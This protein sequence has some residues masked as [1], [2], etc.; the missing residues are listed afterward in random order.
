MPDFDV[1]SDRL[2]AL[3][4]ESLKES[5]P[6]QSH[7]SYLFPCR[8]NNR[9]L[10]LEAE[11]RQKRQAI[12]DSIGVDSSPTPPVQ[13][14]RLSG[15]PTY[16][17]NG[18]DPSPT[19]PL[20]GE[21]LSDSPFPGREG[22]WGVRSADRQNF[23]PA[24]PTNLPH[25]Q[26][27][28]RNRWLELERELQARR[29]SNILPSGVQSSIPPPPSP[30]PTI[31][32]QVFDDNEPIHLQ[33]PSSSFPRADPPI[34]NNAPFP[35]E[36]ATVSDTREVAKSLDEGKSA[37]IPSVNFTTRHLADADQPSPDKQP[38]PVVP[39]TSKPSL[40]KSPTLEELATALLEIINQQNRPPVEVTTS[41][42][43]LSPPQPEINAN[44]GNTVSQQMGFNMPY[45]TEFDLG[46]MEL[47]QLFDTFDREIEQTE[48]AKVVDLEQ[49]FEE[50]DRA[51]DA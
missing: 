50:F 45:A 22:G 51:L 35:Q 11:L 21:G 38:P 41:S 27:R 14:E 25:Y 12:R 34:G 18:F 28:G 42:T 30:K 6:S 10:A 39:D 24:P 40:P 7:S 33:Y 36:V 5:C 32:R 19:P 47:E 16:P 9:L 31:Q 23:S 29:Q 8:G 49:R 26:P 37:A 3:P 48:P 1:S 13:G 43:N 15:S 20:Q 4:Q 17:R 2:P 46:T 44:S